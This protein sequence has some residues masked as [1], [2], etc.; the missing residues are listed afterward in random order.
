M[1]W[2]AFDS[3]TEVSEKENK[4]RKDMRKRQEV[5]KDEDTTAHSEL[6]NWCTEVCNLVDE[7]VQ[8]QSGIL[9][10]VVL[11]LYTNC[12]SFVEKLDRS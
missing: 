10:C 4:W 3:P 2:F 9:V 1:Y 11:N 8:T 6:R 12:K 7:T 5:S